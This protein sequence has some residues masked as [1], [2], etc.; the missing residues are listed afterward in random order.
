LLPYYEGLSDGDLT[1]IGYR[2]NLPWPLVPPFAVT[3][4]VVVTAWKPAEDGYGWILRLQ[5]A[6]GTGTRATL[7][8]DS[9]RFVCRNDLLERALEPCQSTQRFQADLHKHGI[10]TLRIR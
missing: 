2:Y 8:F 6:G 7:E 1:R 3:G 5:D 4:D 9:P 10:L